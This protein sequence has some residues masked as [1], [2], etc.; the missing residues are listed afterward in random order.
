[1]YSLLV[2]EAASP[3]AQEAI[4][5]TLASIPGIARVL[6]L[7]TMHL[8]PDE[9]LVVGSIEMDR[10]L[11]ASDAAGVIDEA[12]ARL[13]EAVP[14]ARIIYLEPQLPTTP[15]SP[16]RLGRPGTTR[17][18]DLGPDLCL[19]SGRPMAG[20]RNRPTRLASAR[21][22]ANER[23]AIATVLSLRRWR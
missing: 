2:G 12:Q 7:R 17:R 1:M 19:G 20:S 21:H 4:R 13:E 9:L 6:R 14:N 16:R 22:G 11:S 10:E 3:E 15:Q 5:R 23:R 18:K 8:G